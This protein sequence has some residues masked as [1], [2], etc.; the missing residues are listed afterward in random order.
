MRTLSPDRWEQVRTAFEEIV[1]L[2]PRA[3]ALVHRVRHRTPDLQGQLF[4]LPLP[5]LAMGGGVRGK[6]RA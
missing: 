2:A 5:H 3:S 6:H 1:D 4:H